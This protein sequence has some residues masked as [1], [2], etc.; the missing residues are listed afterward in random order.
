MG[1]SGGACVQANASSPR[2][3]HRLRPVHIAGPHPPS[4]RKQQPKSTFDHS[5]L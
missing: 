1:T 3:A 2:P 4:A 5:V